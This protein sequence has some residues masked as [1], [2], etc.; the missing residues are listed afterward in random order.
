MAGVRLLSIEYIA[1]ETH[2]NTRFNPTTFEYCL[3]LRMYIISRPLH[4]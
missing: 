4:Q 2:N 3:V 1:I